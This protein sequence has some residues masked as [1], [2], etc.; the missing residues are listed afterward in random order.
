MNTSCVAVP[1]RES[2]KIKAA[3]SATY[4]MFRK[5]EKTE[6]EIAKVL[7]EQKRNF[8]RYNKNTKFEFRFC[9]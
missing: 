5:T 7:L 6:K 2:G 4:P 9:R 8:R 3:M 1:I